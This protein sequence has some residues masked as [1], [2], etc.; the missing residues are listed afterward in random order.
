MDEATER[1]KLAAEQRSERRLNAKAI[2]AMKD[3]PAGR[4]QRAEERACTCGAAGSGEGHTEW[5]PAERFD[6]IPPNMSAA[7][8]C[9]RL[10]IK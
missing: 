4:L 8:A 6:H 9:R 5:C 10:R 7:D 1:A 3:D 2:A